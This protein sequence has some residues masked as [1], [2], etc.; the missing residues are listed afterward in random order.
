MAFGSRK[1]RVG[2]P[3]RAGTPCPVQEGVPAV[4]ARSGVRSRL[5][6]FFG[7][8]GVKKCGNTTS[9]FPQP[10][11]TPP[12]VLL[13]QPAPK[14]HTK[15]CSRS[16]G[17]SPGARTL[18]FPAFETFSSCEFRASI[19]RTPFCAILLRSPANLA[20]IWSYTYQARKKSTKINFL[21]PETARCGGGLPC[22]GVVAEKFVSSLESLSSLA[23]EERNLGSPGNFGGMSRTPGGVRKVCAKKSS[24]AF[25]VP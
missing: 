3:S 13:L 18:V 17:D 24:C 22:K 19:A 5:V 4:P 6:V 7:L 15:G 25:F 8:Y 9:R 20:K 2:T 10:A 14:Y 12:I 16:S 23:F 11:R 1:P 21:G